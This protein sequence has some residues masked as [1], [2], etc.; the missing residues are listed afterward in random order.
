MIKRNM[1]KYIILVE[2]PSTS[3]TFEKQD[4]LRNV[5]AMNFIT[6]GQE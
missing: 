4:M 1:I 3:Q 2:Q 6:K 5:N